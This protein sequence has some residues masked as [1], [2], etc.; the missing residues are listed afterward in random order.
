[1]LQGS[2]QSRQPHRTAKSLWWQPG[3]RCFCGR[4]G[5]ASTQAASRSRRQAA[6]AA[7]DL[8]LACRVLVEGSTASSAHM[9]PVLQPTLRMLPSSRIRL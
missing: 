2:W 8:R 6:K 5:K 7:A 3:T 9:H 1:M 4:C